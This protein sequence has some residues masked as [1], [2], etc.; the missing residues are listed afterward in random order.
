MLQRGSSPK[1]S[2]FF[3]LKFFFAYTTQQP[4]STLFS[5]CTV[6][7]P[8]SDSNSQVNCLRNKSAVLK[9]PKEASKKYKLLYVRPTQKKT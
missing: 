1:S 5:Y 4:A 9:M 6:Q 3:P 8:K 7:K 2:E